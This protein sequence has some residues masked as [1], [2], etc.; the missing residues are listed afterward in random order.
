[1]GDVE[2]KLEVTRYRAMGNITALL[3]EVQPFPQEKKSNKERAVKLKH[4]FATERVL[5]I[6]SFED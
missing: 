2:S 4:R 6:T 5:M 1:M 3:K